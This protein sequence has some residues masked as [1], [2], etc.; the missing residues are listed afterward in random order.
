ML[1][2]DFIKSSTLSIGGMVIAPAVRGLN[3]PILGQGNK[4]YKLN[5]NWSQANR[6]SFPVKDCHEMVQDKKGR[7][8]LLTNET[9]NNVLIYDQKG[10]LLSTWGF[11]YPGAHG[12]T[13]F[14]E[15]G[16]EVLFICDNNRH[17]VIK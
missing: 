4:R 6:N 9:R 2:R 7:I 5:K 8:I 16:K 1:R 11:E 17:Q 12:L 15:N 3:E 13:L 10:K 14:D